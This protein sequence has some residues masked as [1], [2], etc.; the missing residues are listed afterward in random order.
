M[1]ASIPTPDLQHALSFQIHQFEQ[2]AGFIIFRVNPFHGNA[3]QQ[4]NLNACY[5]FYIGAAFILL[6]SENVRDYEVKFS[7]SALLNPVT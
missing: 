1:P 4:E 2:G 5:R 3:F 7:I 6:I